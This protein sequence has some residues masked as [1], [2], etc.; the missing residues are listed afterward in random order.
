MW[1]ESEALILSKQ[2]I[3]NGSQPEGPEKMFKVPQNDSIYVFKQI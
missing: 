2:N 1:N 3:G